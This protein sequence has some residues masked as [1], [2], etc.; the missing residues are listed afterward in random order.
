M[1]CSLDAVKRNGSK[2]HDRKIVSYY[3]DSSPTGYRRHRWVL[4]EV[5]LTR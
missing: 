2:I 5:S 3:N 4:L 1:T